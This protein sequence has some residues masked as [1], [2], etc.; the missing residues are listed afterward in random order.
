[1]SKWQRQETNK[2]DDISNT[3]PHKPYVRGTQYQYIDYIDVTNTEIKSG[4]L[5]NPLD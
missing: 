5:T 1:M 3:S 4:R 2:K